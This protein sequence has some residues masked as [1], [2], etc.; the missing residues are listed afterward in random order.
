MK[1]LL[2]LSIVMSSMLLIGCQDT[3]RVSL[4]SDD[5]RTLYERLG[6]DKGITAVTDDFLERLRKDP[7]VDLERKHSARPF[8]RTPANLTVLRLRL[9]AQLTQVTGGPDYYASIGGRDMKSSHQG[10]GITEAEWKIT[11]DHL[12]ASLDAKGVKKR[13]KDEL[14][15]LVGTL[16]D[17]IVEKK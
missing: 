8:E 2:P 3:G 7:R 6:G 14:L 10:M 17:Q 15:A 5:H 16:H 9:I 11:A 4:T 12:V 1:R 13:E